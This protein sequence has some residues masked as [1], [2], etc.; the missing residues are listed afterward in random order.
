MAAR[1]ARL[2]QVAAAVD[3]VRAV[4]LPSRSLRLATL[5]HARGLSGRLYPGL[6]ANGPARRRLA[7][8][9]RLDPVASAVRAVTPEGGR[10]HARRSGSISDVP[11]RERKQPPTDT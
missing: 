6:L 8:L 1:K 5:V 10:K 9:T 4:E 2:A 11:R 7:A 3:A